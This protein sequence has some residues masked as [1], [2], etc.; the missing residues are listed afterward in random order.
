MNEIIIR[1][2]SI[3]ILIVFIFDLQ[4][5]KNIKYKKN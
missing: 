4:E 1:R 2:Y 5:D 3:N